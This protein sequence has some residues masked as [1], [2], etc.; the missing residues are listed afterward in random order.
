[1][2]DTPQPLPG[3]KSAIADPE[4]PPPVPRRREGVQAGS[5]G[6][7]GLE[8]PGSL[9]Q[10]VAALMLWP[11]IDE[12]TFRLVARCF[13]DGRG[14]EWDFLAPLLEHAGLV[15]HGPLQGTFKFQAQWVPA[16]ERGVVALG[17]AD[18]ARSQLVD[19][20]LEQPDWN[21]VEEIAG[22]AR[23]LSRWD[24]VEGIWM[25]LDEN[26]GGL[27][28]KTLAVF[29]DLPLEARKARPMLTWASGAAD[30]LLSDASRQEG[31]AALQRLLLD[32]ALLH[33]DWSL[34]EDT[35]TAVSAGTI[36]M[37]GER[38]LPTTHVGQ[39][40]EAAWRTKQEIDAF[41][42]SRSRTGNGPGRRQQ[43]V[44]R[45]F[46][47]RLALFLNDPLRAISEA[48][49]AALLADWQP[50]SALASGVEALAQSISS[51]DRPSRRS[52]STLAGVDDD[53]GVSGLK[54]MGQA[55]EI[56]ADGNEGLRRL[57]REEVERSLSVISSD[58]AAIAGVWSV[59][60]ALAGFR[61]AL[62]GDLG[63]GVNQLSAEI[64]RQA[65]LGR[66][67]E[68]PLGGAMLTRARI[69]LLTKAGA[70]GAATQAVG[71]LAGSLKLLPLARVHLW[72]GQFTRAVRVADAGPYEAGLEL[73][74]RYRLTLLK[75]AAALLDGRC[76]TTLRR[77][78]VDELRRLFQE[79]SFLQIALMPRPARDALIDLYRSDGDAD[80]PGLPLLLGR[81]RELNDS[82]E[83]GIRP[84]QL[85]EREM[86][87]LPLLATDESV[88][89]IARNLQVSVNTVRKQ[90]VTLRAKFRAET[91]AELVRKAR[92]Y[93]AIP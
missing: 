25:A 46:S 72:A 51:D 31:E 85:T 21:L 44:F 87:L 30:S 48:R 43:A 49:W 90:V 5:A 58:A 41:I 92:A 35:D 62:W 38:R 70:F 59:R 33:A 27:P 64:L 86:L 1:M 16:L 74:D 37:I 13:G 82:G 39:S 71:T 53:F 89:E 52:R 93:G 42:D 2:P 69:L 66:E 76:G 32:S 79:E 10:W 14:P 47:A 19:A 57:D 54:G 28:V 91:R 80:D 34:R 63:F 81:L 55:F 56:L 65:I 40:L 60:A 18:A 84:V 75:A 9:G 29:R 7:S 50:V 77:D 3:R 15:T 67:Q 8:L 83:G 23:D 4:L 22:W 20:W 24:A 26:T 6:A 88:P 11:I 78:A 68:E 61:D 12:P 17:G 73:V 36:R 45:A